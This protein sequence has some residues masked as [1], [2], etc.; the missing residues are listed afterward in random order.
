MPLAPTNGIEIFYETFGSPDE[1]AVLLIRGLGSQMVAWREEFCT[2]LA[3]RGFHV[4]RF[5]NRDVGL[6]TKLDGVE[7][8]IDDMAA[9]TVGLLDHLGIEA[10]HVV[11]MSMGGMIA[12]QVAISYPE[13]VVS[14]TSLAS[15]IGGEDVVPP[16]SEAAAIFVGPPSRTREEAVAKAIADRRV[17]GSPGFP[18]DEDDIA[19][20]AGVAYDRCYAPEGRMRQIVAIRSAPGRCEALGSVRVPTLVIHGSD[21]PLVPV[22][23]GRRTAEAIPGAE[24][25][26]IPG[27]GH[28]TPRGAWPLLIDAIVSIAHRAAQVRS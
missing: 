17:I 18:F 27:M 20:T 15:H 19:D 5:D 13:R 16:T 6:S 8:T 2:A 1:V 26:V 12:Q 25:F 10:A 22:E 24:L 4:I 11:G 9:D 28:D 7:Y 21:D 3:D 14:L 23:N